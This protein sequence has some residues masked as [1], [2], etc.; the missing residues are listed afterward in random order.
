M[1]QH[2]HI[3]SSPPCQCIQYDWNC[4]P[5]S[6]KIGAVSRYCRILRSFS[7]GHSTFFQVM[8]S[9]TCLASSQNFCQNKAREQMLPALRLSI[10]QKPTAQSR[11]NTADFLILHSLHTVCVHASMAC[12]CMRPLLCLA[13][14]FLDS[15]AN[16]KMD[17]S[18]FSFSCL[19]K[20]L[21]KSLLR[22]S[23]VHSGGG[24]NI[25]R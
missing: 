17:N 21:K 5:S 22:N 6:L 7:N 1:F 12:I 11:L 4:L 20:E 23:H 19:K 8:N 16:I 13:N 25:L 10:Q 24:W 9:F 14:S 15:Y 18:Y 2:A 3:L